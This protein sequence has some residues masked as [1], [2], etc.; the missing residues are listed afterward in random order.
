MKEN[1]YMNTAL[2]MEIL[3]KLP[4]NRQREVFNYLQF[5]YKKSIEEDSEVLTKEEIL[6]LKERRNAYLK[7]PESGISLSE[8]KKKLLSKYGL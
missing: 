8:A 4:F 5:I 1:E 3:E 2:F 6:E 7:K